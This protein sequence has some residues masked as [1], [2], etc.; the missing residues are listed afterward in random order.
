[1]IS[2]DK[3]TSFHDK[4]VAGLR[5]LYKYD[6]LTAKEFNKM[7]GTGN[8]VNLL[9]IIVDNNMA[10]TNAPIFSDDKKIVYKLTDKGKELMIKALSSEINF[11]NYDFKIR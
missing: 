10:K 5:M 8:A 6:E 1:M 3:T 7:M 4:M 2:H 11:N 9:W